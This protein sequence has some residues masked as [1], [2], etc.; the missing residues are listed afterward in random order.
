MAGYVFEECQQLTNVIIGNGVINIES[1]TFY[2]CESLTTV[3]I[4]NGATSIGESSFYQCYSL[5]SLTLGNS[6][7]NIGASAF[8]ACYSLP[9]L[10]LPAGVTSIGKLAFLQCYSLTGVYFQGN[11]PSI[12]VASFAGDFYATNYYLLGTTGW[13]ST[14][15]GRPTATWSLAVQ[16]SI[17]NAGMQ[18]GQFGFNIN[19]TGVQSVVVQA[20]ADLANPV[21]QPVSTNALT[22][23]TSHFSDPQWTNYASRFYRLRSP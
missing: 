14:F 9:S 16:L 23:G 12:G 3:K 22:G 8:S 10:I 21:W 5:T 19:G 7:T 13:G 2:D 18:G 11:A 6:I 15:G 4:G 17:A 20:A 1:G